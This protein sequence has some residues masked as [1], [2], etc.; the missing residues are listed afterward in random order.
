VDAAVA[1]ALDAF[2]GRWAATSFDERVAVVELAAE[3]VA[4]RA[5]EIN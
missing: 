3:A 2:E 4:A 5:G 1:A